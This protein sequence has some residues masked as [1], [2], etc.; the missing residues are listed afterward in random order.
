MKT[1][2]RLVTDAEAVQAGV[3]AGNIVPYR[4]DDLD[5]KVA[6]SYISALLDTREEL[7]AALDHL[8]S[9]AST[10][11]HM[12]ATDEEWLNG[13]RDAR[14]ILAQVRGENHAGV[15]S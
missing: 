6:A 8:S 11:Y 3:W 10:A 13:L 2:R 9:H 7:I 1:E 15:Q 5:I 14:A 12:C 4:R